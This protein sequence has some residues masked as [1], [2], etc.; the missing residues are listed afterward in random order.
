LTESWEF[1]PLRLFFL[2][3]LEH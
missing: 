3:R 1:V 2:S